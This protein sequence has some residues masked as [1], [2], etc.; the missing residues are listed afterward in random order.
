MREPRRFERPA[1][2]FTRIALAAAHVVADPLSAKDPWLE[3]AIDWDAWTQQATEWL[4][5]YVRVDTVNP[6]GNESRACAWLAS[7]TCSVG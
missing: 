7:I 5:E 3:P 1:R 4:S 2:P 6:P